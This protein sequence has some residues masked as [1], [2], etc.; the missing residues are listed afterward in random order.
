LK[1]ER[2]NGSE[3]GGV[4]ERG[5]GSENERLVQSSLFLR[6]FFRKKF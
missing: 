2:E 6:S 3:S 5:S 4:K 1:R